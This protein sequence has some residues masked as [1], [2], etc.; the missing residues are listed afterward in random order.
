MVAT[1][2]KGASKEELKAIHQRII[3]NSS[4]HKKFDAHK[5]CGAV[6]FN[7]DGLEIQKKLRDEWR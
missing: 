5:F 6:K 7:E 2:K 4:A 3:E 1:I